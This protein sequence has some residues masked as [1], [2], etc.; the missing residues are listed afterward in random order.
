MRTCAIVILTVFM[1]IST[2]IFFEETAMLKSTDAEQINAAIRKLWSFNDAERRDGIEEIARL[3]PIA[4]KPLSALL[5]DLI[6]N[7]HPRFPTG[8]EDEGKK[9]LERYIKS[10]RSGRDE[11]EEAHN[12]VS[13]LAIN[14]RLMQDAICLLGELK[15][16]EGVPVLIRI[17]EGQAQNSRGTGY[18]MIALRRIGSAAV[19]YLIK[20]IEESH[21]RASE[22][23]WVIF[24]YAIELGE[25]EDESFP[26]QE[27]QDTDE[28]DEAEIKEIAAIIRKKSLRVLGAIGD[29]RAIPFLEKLLDRTQDKF[30]KEDIEEAI[31]KIKKVKK[32]PPKE[33]PAGTGLTSIRVYDPLED[34]LND[35]CASRRR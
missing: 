29:L 13:K 4:A 33:L 5:S 35:S 24:G 3:G 9:A 23:D 1:P 21:A 6:E 28:D 18:E 31:E 26:D 19:P 15:A 22:V 7:H 20:A 32:E 30:E 34:E 27:N 11:D 17:M 16:E 8:K 10:A 14:S 12:R 2:P 25:A